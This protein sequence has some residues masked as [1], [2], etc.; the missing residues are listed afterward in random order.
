MTLAT[1]I[2][3]QPVLFKTL[4]AAWKTS[5][6]TSFSV[7][8]NNHILFQW[9]DTLPTIMPVVGVPIHL[10]E[11]IVGELRVTG[12]T[13]EETY[14]RLTAEAALIGR[15]A[16]LEH[17]LRTMTAELIDCQDQL[18]A[19]YKLTQSTR[20]HLE[21]DET[22]HSLTRE[23][24]RL[25]KAQFAFTVLSP[26]V[27]VPTLVQYPF[28][29]LDEATSEEFF[30]QMQASGSEILIHNDD[31]S[32]V[33][34]PEIF[35]LF[36][37]PIQIRSAIIAGG[38]GLVN[39]PGSGFTSPDLKLVRAIA[40]HAGA[41]IER[42]LFYQETISQTRLQTEMKLAWDVQVRLL[43]QRPP[44]VKGL[45]IF[46]RSRPASLV[47]G[48]FY[49]FITHPTR[50]FIFTV[51]DVTGKGMSAALLMTMTRTA[52]RSKATFMPRPSPVVLMNRSNEDLYDDFTE[53]GMFA[54]VFL[55][56]YEPEY[57]QILYS[58]A[59]HSPVIYRPAN[60]PTRM[61][62]ADGPPMG[63]L[64]INLS[65][66]QSIPFV[67]GDLLVV[68]TDGFSE[69]RDP[70][71]QM[72]GYERLLRLVDEY[73]ELSAA[74]IASALFNAVQRFTMNRPQE[75]DQTLVV[76]KGV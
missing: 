57:R 41:L 30:H 6:A 21:I 66:Q 70:G 43:P 12:L 40:E 54:T 2:K 13:Y 1:V 22:L 31:M 51:G 27:G 60:G 62:K 47:G 74:E 18:I 9:P 5:G 67:P 34:P 11:T 59:G 17:E 32:N 65:G 44:V 63:G 56:Q 7:W 48:D 38:L 52:I 58:N 61:L 19:L 10:G 71:G 3:A 35:N 72:F 42:T 37:V 53:I 14:N 73:A 16:S 29:F 75:D 8:S 33:L 26:S 50:P 39:K 23:A 76:I 68:A 45:D 64:P 28:P 69:A 46:A 25:V 15:L 4:A 24:A 36:F 49:D 55:G 20:N